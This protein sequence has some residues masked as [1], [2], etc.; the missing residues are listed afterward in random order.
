[1]A[2]YIDDVM[3]DY[4]KEI[5]RAN[6]EPFE[7]WYER[8]QKNGMADRL[9]TPV[10]TK[11]EPVSKVEMPYPPKKRSYRWVIALLV[12]GN[13]LGIYPPVFYHLLQYWESG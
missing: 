11:V 3:W 12:I 13:G 2:L 6:A 9:K 1:M 4:V 5:R 8:T 10:S 7:D